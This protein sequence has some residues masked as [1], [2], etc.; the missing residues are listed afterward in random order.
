[1][2]KESAPVFVKIHNYREVL[3]LVD[4]LKHKIS[5]SKETLNRL[6][7]IKAEEDTEL[8]ETSKDLDDVNRKLAY[9]DKTLFEPEL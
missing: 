8:D 7:E 4:V 5:E 6:H 2:Q 3:D 1:M 9:L